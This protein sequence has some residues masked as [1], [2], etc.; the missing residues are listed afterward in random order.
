MD[1]PPKTMAEFSKIEP[2]P[3]TKN[4]P[5]SAGSDHKHPSRAKH[6]ESADR[7]NK[8]L[9]SSQIGATASTSSQNSSNTMK[10]HIESDFSQ[11]SD[12]S[13]YQSEVSGVKC[14]GHRVGMGSFD[15]F[16]ELAQVE[17][18]LIKNIV[19]KVGGDTPEILS[20]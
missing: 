4:E 15:L 16:T 19:Q 6:N 8:T 11:G 10:G 14:I 1:C 12:D 17:P 5:K 18:N 9:D 7:V 2:K 20:R 13:G 3:D